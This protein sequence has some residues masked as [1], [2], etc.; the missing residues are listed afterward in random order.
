MSF[1]CE[2]DGNKG[3]L[4]EY[5]AARAFKRLSR[6][7]F[8]KTI[9]PKELEKMAKRN[10]K[11]KKIYNEVGKHLGI[12]LANIADA[13]NPE[14]IYLSGKISKAGSLLTKPAAEEMKKRIIVKPP[15]LKVVRNAELYGAASLI[16]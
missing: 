4:E 10:K 13:F 14:V 16:K 3:C 2:L 12:G 11:A 8:G 15:K 6:K 7:Y 1:A 5:V 9:S